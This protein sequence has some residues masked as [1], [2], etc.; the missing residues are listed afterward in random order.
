M[1]SLIQLT[2]L[3]VAPARHRRTRAASPGE[4]PSKRRAR[5]LGH[6]RVHASDRP[7]PPR[8]LDQASRTL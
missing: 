6:R 8:Y 7:S 2:L 4:A 3:R 5:K 1:K